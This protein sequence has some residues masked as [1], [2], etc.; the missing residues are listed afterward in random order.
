[1]SRKPDPRA[2]RTRD[3]LGDALIALMQ[4]Q[5]FDSI[6]VQDVLDLARV[7]R[8]TFYAHFR[9]KEDLLISDV[10]DFW[11]MFATALS[12]RRDQ[13]DRVAPVREV[14]EHVASAHVLIAS[15]TESGK[16]HDVMELGRLHFARGIEQRLATLPR[17]ARL[18]KARRSDLAHAYAGALMALMARYLE[19]PDERRAAEMDEFFHRIVW[20]S[21]C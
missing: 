15:L 6:K 3:R 16:L 20:S 7:G 21:A 17:T 10:D 13:S 4:E 12:R 9:D 19:R 1:M 14:F 18:D 8:S 11:G 5:E 2:V